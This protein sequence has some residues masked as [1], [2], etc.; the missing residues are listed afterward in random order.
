MAFTLK[1]QYPIFDDRDCI[2]GSRTEA[3]P[4]FGAFET[5]AYAF[6]LADK[7]YHDYGFDLGDGENVQVW[8]DGARVYRDLPKAP[9]L[10]D[11]DDDGCP[12]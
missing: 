9:V 7:I 8:S 4:E 2:R 1:L 10:I 12:F 5:A 3:L 11:A 6:K